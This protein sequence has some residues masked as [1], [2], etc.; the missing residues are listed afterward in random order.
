METFHVKWK[1]KYCMETFPHE[2]GFAVDLQHRSVHRCAAFEGGEKNKKAEV[3]LCL[4]LRS[5]GRGRVD[6]GLC[7][8]GS[9]TH[10]VRGYP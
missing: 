10:L 7:N 8:S 5:I 9:D 2:Y 3:V 4:L 1:Q 6:Y